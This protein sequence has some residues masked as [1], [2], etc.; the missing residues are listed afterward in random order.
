M[1]E[2]NTSII[3]KERNWSIHKNP[4]TLSDFGPDV[5]GV[6]VEVGDLY[7]ESESNG[8]IHVH[9][10]RILYELN[11]LRGKYRGGW[12]RKTPDLTGFL[13]VQ[14]VRDTAVMAIGESNQPLYKIAGHGEK[15]HL[16]T[17]FLEKA[18]KNNPG[19]RFTNKLVRIKP[20]FRGDSSLV[21]VNDED[22][23]RIMKK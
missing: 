16:Y 2:N 22:I 19:M 23:K 11:I 3:Y 12:S 8:T 14:R 9:I 17:P 21:T 6:I 18:G 1:A 13:T 5:R 15:I 20:P 10:L 7:M 4:E